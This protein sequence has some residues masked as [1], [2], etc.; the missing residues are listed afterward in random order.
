MLSPDGNQF[1]FLAEGDIWTVPV[2]G[3]VHPNVAGEP[4]RLTNNMEAWEAGNC[5][6]TWSTDG[7]WIAFRANPNDSVYL[8]P[9]SG[10]EPRRVVD[11]IEAGIP[12]GAQMARI[13]V[14]QGGDKI[15][16]PV[17]SSGLFTIQGEGGRAAQL[18]PGMAYEP[19]LS[20]NGKLV[21]YIKGE[22]KNGDNFESIMVVPARCRIICNC[23]QILRCSR[24]PSIRL[25]SERR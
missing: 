15:V 17:K 19:A 22:Q 11:G 18:V 7:Q 12:R 8:V 24:F 3:G 10:G 6:V 4:V 23:W 21:A 5:T 16:F 2:S 25:G 13:S 14:F 1:A 9:A 20:P